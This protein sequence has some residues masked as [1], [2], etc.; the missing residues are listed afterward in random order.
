MPL[1]EQEIRHIAGLAQLE[2][3]AGD[4]ADLTDKL[5]RIVEFVDQL[6]QVDL[7]RCDADGASAGY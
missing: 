6:R 4:V 3:E 1:S 7:G 5:G 2:I